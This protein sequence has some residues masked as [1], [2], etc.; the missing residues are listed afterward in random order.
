[1]APLDGSIVTIAIPSIASSI[2]LGL[3]T[4]VWIP[5]AYLL[6]LTVLLINAGRLADLRG[7]KR[8]YILGFIIFTT[9]S[10]LC[11]ASATGLQLVMFRAVQGVGAAF[12][13][14][15]AAAIVT[16]AF[17]SSERGKALGINATAVYGGLMTGPVIGGILVQSFGWRSIFYVNV[18]IGIAVVTL[19]TLR[20]KDTRAKIE[21]EGFDFAGAGTLSLALASLLVALTLGGG[22]GWLSSPIL[23]LL[24]LSAG[25]FLLFIYVEGRLARFPTFQLRM[26]ANNR[27]FAAAN[28][29]AFLSY[30]AVTGVTFLTSIYLQDVKGLDPQEA[31]I[32]LI[33]M[34]TAMALLSP[35]SGWLSDRFG[36]RLLGS[37]GM[38]IVSLGLILLSRLS[39]DSSAE[40]VVVGL[41]VIG[42]G[43]G[44][45]SSPNT[46]AVMGSVQRSELGVAA[47]TLGTMRFMGQSMGLALVGAGIASA[48]APEAILQLLAGLGADNPVAR[49]EFI[50]GMKDVFAVSALVAAIGTV[51][52][53]VRGRQPPPM[54]AMV[55]DSS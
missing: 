9:G 33:V 28:T 21:G 8:A 35:V 55:T 36:S 46:S 15:N 31:G 52:S 51:A 41:L 22:F 50:I 39:I 7:R 13:A 26:F 27:M 29:A 43:F 47:G 40:D 11:G 53:L 24:L 48:L 12:I 4:V 49:E 1:M 25:A 45:F 37:A 3:E 6:L 5:L 34:S 20:L 42:I 54:D 2:K 23:V 17:P 30:I 19:A 14:S 16:D 18:P 32:L 38:I 44:L 10:V